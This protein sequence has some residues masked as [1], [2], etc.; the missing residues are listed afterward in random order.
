VSAPRLII[1]DC[2][3]TLVDSQHLI[4][5]AM[6]QAFG[7]ARLAPPP[8]EAVLGM[9]GLSLPQ[10]IWRLTGGGD[11]E[12]VLKIADGYRSAFSVLRQDPDHHE[13]MYD[14]AR[15]AILHLVGE[16]AAVLGIATGKS[17]RG[18][19]RLLE[20]FGLIRHFATIQTADDAPSKPHPGMI[21]RALAETG[22][23]PSTA[24]MIGDTTFDIEMA[25]NAGIAG[26]GVAWGYHPA[27]ELQGAGARAVASDYPHLLELLDELTAGRAAAE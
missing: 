7:A 3:G 11:E 17:R 21:E 19:D 1:F 15:E 20:R 13:P 5:A 25:R 18:V 22:L 10:A 23:D 2:D 24:V 9:V 6:N 16:Q 26:I 12:T 8:R 27:D 4:V 14:G